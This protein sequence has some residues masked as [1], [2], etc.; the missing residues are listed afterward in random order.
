[1]EQ[2]IIG[3]HP[4]AFS[5]VHHGAVAAPGITVQL[6]YGLYHP[7]SHG[8][9]MD[10]PDQ[11]QK[12]VVLITE[13]GFVAVLEEMAGAAMAAI[14]IQSVPGEEFSHDGGD[15]G[16]AALEKDVDVIVHE[17]PGI[18]RALTLRDDLAESFEEPGFVFVVSEDVRLVDPPDHDVVKGAGDV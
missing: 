16:L 7:G 13:D 3:V 17:D 5:F 2:Y 10:V 4:G 6:F 9:E 12:I 18:D 1:L 11:G 14:E 15:A 8:I